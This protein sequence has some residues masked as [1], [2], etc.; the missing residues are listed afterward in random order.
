MGMLIG[1]ALF[2]FVILAVIVGVTYVID[3]NA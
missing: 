2:I 3:R 1:T